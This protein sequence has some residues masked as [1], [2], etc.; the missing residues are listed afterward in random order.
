[1]ISIYSASCQVYGQPKRYEFEKGLMGSPFRLLFYASDDSLA[2][3][4]ARQAFKRIESLNEILSD[5]RDGSEINRLSAQ[6]GSGKWVAV[7][8]DLYN[9]LSISK[10]ISRKTRGT[11]D[12]TVGPA[13]QLWRRAMRRNVFPTQSEIEKSRKATGFRFIKLRPRTKS[14]RLVRPGMRLDAGGIGKGY[15]A[16]EAV[17]TLQEMGIRAVLVD[18]GGDLTLAAPPPGREGWEVEINSGQSADSVALVHL[19][20]VGVAT[21]GD[22][23]RY[24]EHE[25][26]R[27][28]HI[29][30]PK[31][32]IGL[33]HHVRTTVIAP[34]GTYADALAT[35]FSVAGGE[36]SKRI[37]RRFAGI[38]VWLLEI[39][40][41]RIT[42]WSTL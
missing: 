41:N 10:K 11:F 25:G 39:K 24:L 15:A 31:T 28:S 9:V 26:I 21:S 36:R 42:S 7:S 18:A 5:Y 20:N 1:M 16:D 4:A 40:D 34:N 14:V 2:S 27:Y 17:R 12:I 33:L 37:M 29:L 6:S 13:V 3:E 35:A 23:Y 22:N 32:G 30:D 8:D 19:T 38:R